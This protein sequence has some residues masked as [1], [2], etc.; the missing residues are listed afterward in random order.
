MY[1]ISPFKTTYFPPTDATTTSYIII[2]D[3]YVQLLCNIIIL[4]TTPNTNLK[5]IY[6]FRKKLVRERGIFKFGD[7][8]KIMII[9]IDEILPLIMITR[10]GWNYLHVVTNLVNSKYTIK[11]N[12]LL[13]NRKPIL[14]HHTPLKN[15]SSLCITTWIW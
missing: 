5:A 2:S 15:D 1:I 12:T 13:K 8:M 4:K 7:L 6:N 3:Y 10:I 14:C 11:V 9:N